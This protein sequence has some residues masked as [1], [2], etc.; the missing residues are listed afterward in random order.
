MYHGLMRVLVAGRLSR[1]VYDVDQSGLDTQERAAVAWAEANGHK[2][3]GVAADFRSARSAMMDRPNLRPWVT[4]PEKIALYDAIAALKVD[5]LTRGDEAETADLEQWARDHGKLLITVDG[6]QYPSNGQSAERVKWDLMT[7]MAHDEWLKIS[8]RYRRMQ[9]HKR[10]AGYLVG[11]QP[12]GYRTV[13]DGKGKRLEPDPA[14]APVVVEM[15][16]RFLGGEPLIRIAEWLTE[17]GIPAPGGGGYWRH[18]SVKKIL[19][20][21]SIIGRRVNRAGQVELEYEG[22]LDV[23]TWQQIKAKL[24]PGKTPRADRKDSFPAL[25]KGIAVCAQCGGPMYASRYAKRRKNGSEVVY[26]YYKCTGRDGRSECHN[27]LPLAN[28]DEQAEAAFLAIL[29]PMDLVKVR[30]FPGSDYGMEIDNIKTRIGQLDVEADDYDEK[31][32]E[33]RA[34]LKRLRDF[35]V[36]D[37]EVRSEPT[38]ETW[39]HH[40]ESLTSIEDRNRWLRDGEVKVFLKK[41]QLVQIDCSAALN[42]SASGGWGVTSASVADVIRATRDESYDPPSMI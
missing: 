2:V 34:E 17:S 12:F 33:L 36:T 3:I 30:V 38:G 31:L 13:S 37:D 1:K 24:Q 10:K 32:T 35:P 26:G 28:A 15:A 19:T 22:L 27:R 14:L 5:R 42:G 39:A 4:D 9:N 23:A 21:P 16:E 6:C 29:G 7:A 20:S 41:G 11:R 25:L 8:E 40:W 18:G